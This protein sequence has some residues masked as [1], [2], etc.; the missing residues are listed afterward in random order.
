MSGLETGQRERR[1]QHGP[2]ESRPFSSAGVHA[3]AWPLW[4]RAGCQV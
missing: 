2:S 3:R 1:P 4:R